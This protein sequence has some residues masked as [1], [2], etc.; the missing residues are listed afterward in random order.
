MKKEETVRVMVCRPYQAEIKEIPNTLEAFQELVKGPI[1]EFKAFSNLDLVTLCNE[2]GYLRNMAPNPYFV[3][4]VGPVVVCG[5][6]GEEFASLTDA[7]VS[8]LKRLLWRC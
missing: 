6:R 4:I 3:G 7:Q 1:E 8:A 5:K 2:E